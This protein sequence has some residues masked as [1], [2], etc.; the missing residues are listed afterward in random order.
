MIT[1]YI[2]ELLSE[3][4]QRLI[5]KMIRRLYVWHASAWTF[6]RTETDN[7][8]IS[9]HGNKVIAYHDNKLIAYLVNKV[10]AHHANIVVSYQ[11]N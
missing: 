2:L 3:T 1:R 10:K 7:K 9:Y 8:V 5:G 4:A 11:G 6:V